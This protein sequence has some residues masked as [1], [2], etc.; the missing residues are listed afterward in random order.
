MPSLFRRLLLLF[1]A[2]RFGVRLIWLAAPADHKMH[3]IVTLIR[4]VHASERGRAGLHGVLPLLGP[5]AGGFAHN[6][7]VRPELAQGTLHDALNSASHLLEPLPPEAAGRALAAAFGT[8]LADLFESIDLN[9]V[10][11][12]FAHQVHT[13]RL[14]LPIDGHREVE[15]K[16]LRVAQRTQIADETA[17]LRWV[18]RWLEK[19]SPAAR[20]LQVRAL[21]ETFTQEILRRLDLRAEAAN[22]SQTAHLFADDSRVVVP[23]VIWDLSGDATLVI[24]RIATVRA[25]DFA[26]L[27]EHRV[28]VPALAARIIEVVTHEAF[29]HGFFHAALDAR[30]VRVSIDEKTHGKLVLGDFAVMSNLSAD[31]R[32]FFVH[33]ATAL[34]GQHYGRLADLH[35]NAG[36]VPPDARTEQLEAELRTRAEAHFAGAPHERFAGPLFHHLLHAVAPFDGC[37]PPRLVG[38]QRAFEQAEALA[39]ALHP[40]VD[41]WGVAR[42]VLADLARRDFDHRGWAKHLAQELPHLAHL[43]PRVPQLAIRYLQQQHSVATVRQQAQLV[44]EVTREYRRTRT[45]LWACTIC[46]ALLGGLAIL[47]MY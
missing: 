29:E 39:N 10:E 25:T 45:L 20:R 42:R 12:G 33:G 41:S 38:A 37:V 40:G 3:W 13:A 6:L 21:A 34:F 36:H 26:A 1:Y 14:A 16:L 7:A 15:I 27:A 18:A 17:L 22:Q 47:L 9:A 5:L 19:L 24:E 32:A 44:G 35:R 30:R 46:G 28:S 11:S 43:V 31:E 4:R 23:A 2:L 8:P